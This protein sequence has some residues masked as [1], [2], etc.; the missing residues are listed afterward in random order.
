MNTYLEKDFISQVQLR[1]QKY[2]EAIM[3]FEYSCFVSYPH[4]QRDIMMPFIEDFVKGLEKEIFLEIDWGVFYD[5]M[6]DTGDRLEEVLGPKL[7][8]SVC[9]ILFYTP[10]YFQQKHLYCA[11]ELKAMHDLEQKRFRKLGSR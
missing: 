7:C 10:L 8:K 4:S 5:G 3:P 11:R 6:L 9:M 2:G 1:T